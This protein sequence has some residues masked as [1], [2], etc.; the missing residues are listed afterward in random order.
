MIV[1]LKGAVITYQDGDRFEYRGKCDRCN[2]VSNMTYV[3][4]TTLGQGQSLSSSHTCD[5]CHNLQ[6]V[7]LQGG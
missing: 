4:Y 1:A 3:N 7:L 6:E 2:A 5:Q